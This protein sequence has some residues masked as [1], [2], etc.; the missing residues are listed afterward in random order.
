MCR[1][2]IISFEKKNGTDLRHV[3]EAFWGFYADE[4]PIFKKTVGTFLG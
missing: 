2:Q 4:F 1:G 3:F